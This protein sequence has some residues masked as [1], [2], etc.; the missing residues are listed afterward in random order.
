VRLFVALE[1]PE[2]TRHALADLI[3][4]L[5]DITRSARWVRPEGIHVTLKF[6]GEAPPEKLPAIKEALAQVRNSAPVE[7][8]FRGCGF[9]PNERR[10]RVLWIGVEASPNLAGLAATVEAGLEPLGIA[11]EAR[12]FK[13]HLTLARF[14]GAEGNPR[15]LEK[16]QTFEPFDF[17]GVRTGEFHLFQSQLQRGGA[18]YTRL[19]SFPFVEARS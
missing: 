5:K 18:R 4:R 16:L 3:D 17:G 12:E 7:A 13:P 2:E 6:I 19:A 9:F 1:I 8:R 15:L 14:E 11:A 10:P